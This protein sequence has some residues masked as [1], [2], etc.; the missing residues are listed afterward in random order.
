MAGQ[1][2]SKTRYTGVYFNENT[3]KYDIKYNYTIY[4]P[5]KQKNEYKSKWVY[6]IGSIAEAR[7]KLA[8]LRAGGVK[9]E[10]KEITLQGAYDLWEQMIVATR[11]GSPVTIRNTQQHLRMISQFIPLDTKMKDISEDVYLE[12]CS[13]IRKHGYSEETLRSINASLRK[14]INLCFRKKLISE[15]ILSYVDNMRTQQ[16]DDY[17]ILSKSDFDKLDAYFRDNSFVRLGVDNYPLY[18]L[19]VNVLYYCGIRC[20]ELLALTPEDFDF[21]EGKLRVTKSYVSDIQLVKSPKNFK[22]RSI[23]MV[24][25]VME[26]ARDVLT[27][28]KAGKRVFDFGHGAVSSM[29]KS[30]CRKVEIEEY[31]CHAFRHTFISNLIRGSV[32]LPVIERVSGDTQETILKRYSHMFA[33]DDDMILDVMNSL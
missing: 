6:N 14:L 15:N 5:L 9:K 22:K 27:D 19:I 23:P 26:L 30:A 4:N 20:G 2:R 33:D 13:K 18:R 1:K 29:I 17:K 10:D 32:P 28:K 24:E 3:K 11:D 21:E 16:K 7:Q 31:N 25:C 12:F 8:T